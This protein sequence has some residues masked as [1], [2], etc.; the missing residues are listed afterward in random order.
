[1]SNPLSD[2]RAQA[3]QS[4][5]PG[6]VTS[7]AGQFRRVG[8][9]AETAMNGLQGAHNDATWTGQAA[10]LFREKLGKL[11]GDLQKVAQSYGDAATAL[12][13][14][15]S[16]LGQLQ[17]QF[18]A[19]VPQIM[20]AQTSVSNAQN[21]LAT[22]RGALTTA[23][24]T[25]GVKPSDPKIS[26]AQTAVSNAGGAAIGA[27]GSLDGL[28]GRAFRILDE[29]DHVRGQA[30]SAI[31]TAAGIAPEDHSNW[32]TSALGSVGS[33]MKG[34]AVGVWNAA[35]SLPSDVVNVYNHPDDLHAWSKLAGDVG[36]VAGAVALV[37]AV[38]V[39]PLDAVG[40]EGAAALFAST[41]SVAGAVATTAAMTQTEYDAGLA[42]QGKGSWKTVGFDAFSVGVGAVKIP[43][44]KASGTT[45]T[46]LEH[47]TS[48]LQEYSVNRGAGMTATQAYS[49]LTAT[50]RSL[51]ASSTVSLTHN[52]GL[53]TL[54]SSTQAAAT[55]AK[56]VEHRF[57]AGNELA[58]TILDGG[59][60]K[61]QEKVAPPA[62]G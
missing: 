47:T 61:V 39:C 53:S 60:E 57:G 8:T 33:F 26:G 37:A 29:F 54:I 4:A 5:N 1:M 14:Y 51:I 12:T 2:P 52:R 59:K 34:M 36:K 28:D 16:Q 31:S 17:S 19:L 15:G 35:K 18:S 41:D 45:A 11:P 10:D 3:L 49:S 42:M 50:Q 22:A 21:N 48:A 58:H 43:G 44:L 27:Q 46:N 56:A 20:S 30:R 24:T 40:F 38:I 9:Q 25:A 23:Q 7:L 32:F 62:G 13:T 6:E 55:G